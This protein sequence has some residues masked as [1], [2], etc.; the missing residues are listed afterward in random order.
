MAWNAEVEGNYAW[1]T[2]Q[3]YEHGGVMSYID[4]IQNG[5]YQIGH[6]QGMI[7]GSAITVLLTS[8]IYGIYKFYLFRKAR[9]QEIIEQAEL[10]RQA[11]QELYECYIDNEE[12]DLKA[13]S[14]GNQWSELLQ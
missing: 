13:I 9:K 10:A 1:L 6:N 11:L 7:Q 12:I 4:D 8:A 3:A 2:K 14:I 5:G